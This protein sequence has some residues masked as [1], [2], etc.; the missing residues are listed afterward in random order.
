MS[1]AL[2]LLTS[3]ESD[4]EPERSP[5][6][7]KIKFPLPKEIKGLFEKEAK[8]LIPGK[9]KASRHNFML[10]EINEFYHTLR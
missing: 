8:L 7:K 9:E 3:Y 10:C 6:K 2:K 1:H 5:P 4:D